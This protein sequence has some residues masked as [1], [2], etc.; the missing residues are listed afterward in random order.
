MRAGS[1][2]RNPFVFGVFASRVFSRGLT[3]AGVVAAL[4]VAPASAQYGDGRPPAEVGSPL[5]Q[6]FGSPPQAEPQMNSGDL[7]VRLN[8]IEGLVRQLNGQIEQLQFRNQQL[9]Q[10]LRRMQED[11]EFRFQELGGR[12]GAGRPAT[13]PPQRSQQSPVPGQSPAQAPLG[14][15]R[16]SDAFDPAADPTAPGA[17]RSLGGGPGPVASAPAQALPPIPPGDGPVGTP[18]GREFGQP[19][20]ITTLAS[21]AAADPSLPPPP[22]PPV[23][24][25]A[26]PGRAASQPPAAQQAALPPGGGS[27]QADYQRAYNAVLQQDH[28]GA[29]AGFRSFLRTYP[30]DKLAPNATY[31]LG[32]SLYQRQRYR[33]AAEQFLKISTDFPNAQVAPNALLRLGQS[34]AALG[35]R[36]AAC[37]TFVEAGRK[38]PGAPQSV[39]QGLEQEKKRARC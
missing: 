34:L 36:E 26:T 21:R 2:V 22:P 17:P 18:G 30:R 13:P 31:W 20:D 24:P 9:E 32:E 11:Y 19:L 3:A 6:L 14:T 27:P 4:A 10:N 39:R 37:A 12:G 29:E 35:E 33:D 23:I 1:R 25:P 7:V 28:D 8:Q 38:H 5:A 15:Q 16:R